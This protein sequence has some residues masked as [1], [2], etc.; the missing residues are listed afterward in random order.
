MPILQDRGTLPMRPELA[1]GT[2][3]HILR[4]LWSIKKT[5]AAH[6]RRPTALS[7]KP[8]LRKTKT[9]NG[10]LFL[11]LTLGLIG[12]ASAGCSTAPG[13][14]RA[15]SPDGMVAPPSG[16][17]VGT[18]SNPCPQC[19]CTDG[20]CSHCAVYNPHHRFWAHYTPPDKATSCLDGCGCCCLGSCLPDSCLFGDHGP[21]VY[22]ANPTPGAIVQ[23]P[24]YTC[25]GPDDF[26]HP[27]INASTPR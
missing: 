18:P 25:K 8:A 4:I 2:I 11:G 21:L 7:T 9:M 3:L 10:K 14:V 22:P 26:F 17:V 16:A 12:L 24:Y 15:Q 5:G 19:G 20:S 6:A 13:V 27:A 1:L 23:Y